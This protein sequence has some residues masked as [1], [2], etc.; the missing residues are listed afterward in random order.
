MDF[1]ILLGFLILHAKQIFLN[2]LRLQKETAGGSEERAR[3][4]TDYR[5]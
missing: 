1:I 5:Q 4:V 3:H 2:E